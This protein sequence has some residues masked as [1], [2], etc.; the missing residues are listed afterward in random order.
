MVK[1]KRNNQWIIFYHI[2]ER[3]RLLANVS[4][5]MQEVTPKLNDLKQLLFRCSQFCGSAIWAG[6]SWVVHLLVAVHVTQSSIGS[7][8]S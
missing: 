7:T 4:I 6:L 3:V 2:L 8:E 5:A 1:R